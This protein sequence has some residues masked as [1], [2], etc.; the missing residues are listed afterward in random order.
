MAM[1]GVG[2]IAGFEARRGLF[3]LDERALRVMHE[4]WPLIAPC[5]PAAI[6]EM[7][8][9]TRNLPHVGGVIEQHN[10]FIKELETSHYE[11]L[12]GGNLDSRY[13]ESC[14]NTA[15]RETEIGLDSRMRSSTGNF[16]LRAAFKQLARKYWFRPDKL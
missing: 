11:V 13:V 9:L 5:L 8:A 2:F 4:I 12:L 1:A 16:V 6:D 15:L 7:L 14:E 3:G 10:D